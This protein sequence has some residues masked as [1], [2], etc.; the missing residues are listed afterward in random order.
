MFLCGNNYKNDK[1]YVMY[2]KRLRTV[3]GKQIISLNHCPYSRSSVVK[4]IETRFTS[5]EDILGG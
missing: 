4:I 5:Y 3:K 1:V 2:S